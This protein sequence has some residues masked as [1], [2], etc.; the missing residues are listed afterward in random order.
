MIL[1]EI[2]ASIRSFNPLIAFEHIAVLPPTWRVLL[3]CDDP[4]DGKGA[5]LPLPLPLPGAAF[6]HQPPEREEWIED[7]QFE[8]NPWRGE[9]YTA[10][11]YYTY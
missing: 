11:D 3:L 5:F 10:V 7:G 9:Y 8:A 2:L 1:S 4:S 6:P